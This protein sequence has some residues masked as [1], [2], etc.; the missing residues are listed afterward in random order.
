ML[1]S[2][3]QRAGHVFF[4]DLGTDFHSRSCLKGKGDGQSPGNQPEAQGTGRWRLWDFL[5]T[6]FTVLN[7]FQLAGTR[8]SQ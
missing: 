4:G 8:G 5:G 3:W 2:S 7:F 1:P 6:R